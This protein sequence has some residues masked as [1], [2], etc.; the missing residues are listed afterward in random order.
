MS[1]SDANEKK[2]MKEL[3]ELGRLVTTTRFF[4]FAKPYLDFIGRGKMFNLVYV[5]MMAV[6]VLL[7][8]VVI[9]KAAAEDFFEYGARFTAAFMLSWLVIVFACWIGFQLWWDRRLR[10][11]HAASAELIVTP[12]VSEIFQTFGEWIGTLIGILGA[13]V[14]LIAVIT[15][16]DDASYLFGAIGLGFMG[17]GALVIITGPVTGFFIIILSRFLAEQLRLLAALVN[18]TKEIAGNVKNNANGT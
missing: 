2:G 17:S 14:G 18:N 1:D 12:L 7:P 4:T 13:G 5:I 9:F 11:A 15:I 16:G 8:F 10:A 6:N 3:K